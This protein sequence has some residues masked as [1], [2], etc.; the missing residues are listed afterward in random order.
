MKVCNWFMTVVIHS[1]NNS[2]SIQYYNN[3]EKT[4]QQITVKTS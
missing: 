3:T 2:V 1:T 4:K